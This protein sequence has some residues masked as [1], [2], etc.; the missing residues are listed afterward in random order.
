MLADWCFSPDTV[1]GILLVSTFGC[2]STN[3]TLILQILDITQY[4]QKGTILLNI[5]NITEYN[6][7]YSILPTLLNITNITQYYQYYSILFFNITQYS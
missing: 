7:H 2:F 4:H 5:T 6:Q 3:I 1:H